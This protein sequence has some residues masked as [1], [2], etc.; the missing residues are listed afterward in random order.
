M[1]LLETGAL[2]FHNCSNLTGKCAGVDGWHAVI[3]IADFWKI[4][5]LEAQHLVSHILLSAWF[6]WCLVF[7]SGAGTCYICCCWVGKGLDVSTIY[8]PGD[9][10]SGCGIRTPGWAPWGLVLSTPL[11]T[12]AWVSRILLSAWFAWYLV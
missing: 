6:V 5:M 8:I 7:V 12:F 11:I 1:S 4:K 2:T 9:T 3:K 10:F